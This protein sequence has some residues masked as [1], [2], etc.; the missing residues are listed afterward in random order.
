MSVHDESGETPIDPMCAEG[1]MVADGRWRR[2]F[3]LSEDAIAID[4]GKA[5]QVPFG[6]GWSVAG[7]AEGSCIALYRRA[8][9]GE[10]DHEAVTVRD[11]LVSN[12]RYLLGQ[13]V[14]LKKTV[15]RLT[16]VEGPVVRLEHRF[17]R[18]RYASAEV[19]VDSN[20][21]ELISRVV[22]LVDVG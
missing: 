16:T 21:Q 22:L 8:D 1:Y 19:I 3:S 13:S 11:L 5:V 15:W 18:P 7:R 12:P 20:L 9:T 2:V 14:R 10:F 4:S 17:R 6:S